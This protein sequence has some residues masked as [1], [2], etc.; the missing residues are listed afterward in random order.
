MVIVVMSHILGERRSNASDSR[1]GKDSKSIAVE[2][3]MDS[4]ICQ[5]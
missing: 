3:T 4:I 5:Q 2:D 1:S